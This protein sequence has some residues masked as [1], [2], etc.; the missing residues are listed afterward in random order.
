MTTNKHL[1]LLG[2]H[3]THIHG[4]IFDSEARTLT[5]AA[6]TVASEQPSWLVRHPDS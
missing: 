5:R 6:S 1:L 2:T 4:V 3:D